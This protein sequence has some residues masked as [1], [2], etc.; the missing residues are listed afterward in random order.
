MTVYADVL[1]A[2]NILITYIIIVASRVL[3]KIPTNKW[4]VSC[5]CVLG[6]VSSRVIFCEDGGG[7]FSLF[8]K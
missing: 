5:A 4:A 3:C 7:V 1:V 6:G 8:Y 2:L